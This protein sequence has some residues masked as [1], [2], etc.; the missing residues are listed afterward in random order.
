M[1]H[2]SYGI[3]TRVNLDFQAAIS[4]VTEELK[5]EGFGVL[6]EINI[7]EVLKQKLGVDF[8]NY[9]ILGACNPPLAHAT[10]QA[11]TDIGLLLPCNVVVYEDDDGEVVVAAMDPVA[12][13]SVVRN[14]EVKSTAEEVRA[15]VMKVIGAMSR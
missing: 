12:A 4:K 15:R 13:L 9:V 5:R 2:T 14:P 10:L 6:T 1:E 7:K 11:E 8:R 3:K